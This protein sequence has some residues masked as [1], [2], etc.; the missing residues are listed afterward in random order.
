MIDN[1]LLQSLPARIQSQV[2]ADTELVTLT[3]QQPVA[4][5]GQSLE[6]VY[7]PTTSMISVVVTFENG[8]ALEAG[9]VGNDGHTGLSVLLGSDAAHSDMY[10][11][12]PGRAL[13]LEVA[14]LRKHLGNESLRDALASYTA[15]SV[16]ITGQ[17]AGCVAFH[18][19]DQRLARW[20]LMVRDCIQ[21]DD[22]SLTHEFL[23]IMLGVQ[24]P[25][26][27]LC[28]HMLERAGLIERRRGLVKIVNVPALEQAA[29][30]CYGVIR[31]L[32]L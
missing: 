13:R 31:A 20:L 8:N 19:V 12:I 16:A 29:C 23:G 6:H 21:A 14:A 11:Q 27:T 32:E 15:R 25:T 9:L 5:R 24:R 26:V 3:R 30:E 2:M 4:T 28:L 17:L 10:V 22:L 7:F 1:R 18:P